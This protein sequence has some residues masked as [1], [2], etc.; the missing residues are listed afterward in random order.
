[1]FKVE[2]KLHRLQNPNSV[3]E[4]VHPIMLGLRPPVTKLLIKDVNDILLHRAQSVSMPILDSSI[5]FC[6]GAGCQ[7][8]S[9][10][11]PILPAMESSAKDPSEGGPASQCL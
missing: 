11:L 1:M 2:G 6:E 9:T 7:K 3:G 8:S 10:Q 5:R 4:I